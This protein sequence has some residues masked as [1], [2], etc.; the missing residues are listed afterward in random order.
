MLPNSRAWKLLCKLY[1]TVLNEERRRRFMEV[2]AV[3]YFVEAAAGRRRRRS[4]VGAG[5]E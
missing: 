2:G 3:E 5:V 1:G 4:A